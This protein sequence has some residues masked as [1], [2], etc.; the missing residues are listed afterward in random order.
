MSDHRD[1]GPWPYGHALT[2][3]F[4]DV[5]RGTV[6]FEYFREYFDQVSLP[7]E[8][9]KASLGDHYSQY[10]LQGPVGCVRFVP[11]S[12]L[13]KFKRFPPYQ[14]VRDELVDHTAIDGFMLSG[15]LS[16]WHGKNI[17][18]RTPC[19]FISHRWQSPDEPDSDGAHLA[20]VLERLSGV[21]SRADRTGFDVFLWIDYCC[22][23]QR[24]GTKSLSAE[25][26]ASL[27]AGLAF[28]PEIVK[29]CDLMILHSPDYI[30]RV[31]CYT[32][33]F[34]WLTKIAEIGDNL[35]GRP[36]Y[37]SILTRHANADPV[38]AAV[39]ELSPTL[40]DGRGQAAAA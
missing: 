19:V 11:L 38:G 20:A 2:D 37:D 7:M 33:L 5:E 10:E 39:E 26:E 28:L 4:L 17:L 36:L 34:V 15:P 16:M 23:P 12:T 8:I 40:G 1:F 25:D 6:N 22:L 24:R 31:W 21:L 18:A 9:A 30:N 35:T 27:R 32:E 14:D 3:V 29:S 13:R